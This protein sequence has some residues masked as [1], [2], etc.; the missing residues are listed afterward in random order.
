MAGLS[1]KDRDQ[2]EWKMSTQTD[3]AQMVREDGTYPTVP[4]RKE[5]VTVSVVQTEVHGVPGDNPEPALK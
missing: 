1:F 5:R 3:A 2:G 4:L